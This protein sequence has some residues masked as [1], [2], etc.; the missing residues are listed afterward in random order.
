M[1]KAKV[2]TLGLLA[3]FVLAML[4]AQRSLTPVASTTLA[5]EPAVL[6]RAVTLEPTALDRAR[7]AERDEVDALF[8]R[9]MQ[10]NPFDVESVALRLILH[11]DHRAWLEQPAADAELLRWSGYLARWMPH[12]PRYRVEHINTLLATGRRGEAA[13]ERQ[14]FAVL[15]PRLPL[16]ET[17]DGRVMLGRHVDPLV[18]PD[19]DLPQ[20]RQE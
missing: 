9:A 14:A 20:A 15:W 17:A 7:F 2:I 6:A 12:H 5:P 11:R 16:T 10:A 3:L 13:R 1:T 8:A 4:C 19:S 18:V